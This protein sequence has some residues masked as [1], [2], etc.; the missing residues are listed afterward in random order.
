MIHSGNYTIELYL[1]DGIN[2]EPI[3]ITTY[4]SSYN[5]EIPNEPTIFRMPLGIFMI[6]MPGMVIAYTSYRKNKKITK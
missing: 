3:K 5:I 6:G 1:D 2:S 4:K